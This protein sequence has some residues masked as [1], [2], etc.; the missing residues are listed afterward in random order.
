M[1]KDAGRNEPPTPP[2][3]TPTE[4][5]VFEL[6]LSGESEARIAYL[7]RPM[8]PKT[9]HQHIHSISLKC[10]VHSQTELMAKYLRR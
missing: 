1:T 2:R 4:Q 3:L 9:V 7:L 5:K 6:L 10:D 8:R